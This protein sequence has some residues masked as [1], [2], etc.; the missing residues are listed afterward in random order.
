MVSLI[1]WPV[2][3]EL[4]DSAIM[5]LTCSLDMKPIFGHV[6]QKLMNIVKQMQIT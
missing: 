3:M 5:R 4:K 1:A 2:S 6:D